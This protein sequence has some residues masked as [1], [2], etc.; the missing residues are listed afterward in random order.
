MN[1]KKEHRNSVVMGV[2]NLPELAGEQ[3][4]ELEALANRSESE[5]DYSGI[6]PI[7]DFGRFRR[8][9]KRNPNE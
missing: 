4:A 7:K 5:L 6:S 8:P 3:I 1:S 2:G 9:A